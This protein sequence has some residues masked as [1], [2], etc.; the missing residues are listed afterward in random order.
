MEEVKVIELAFDHAEGEEFCKWLNERGYIARIGAS[1]GNYVDGHWTNR[2]DEA[3]ALL[4]Q[5]WSEYCRDY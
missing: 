5:L 2:S 4:N 1:S 3:N